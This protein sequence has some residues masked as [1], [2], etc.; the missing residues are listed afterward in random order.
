M[1]VRLGELGRELH[2]DRGQLLAVSAPGRVELDEEEGVLLDGGGEVGLAE[3]QQPL[4]LLVGGRSHGQ[5]QQQ[6]LPQHKSNDTH[7]NPTDRPV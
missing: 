5:Q 2:E 4:S 3:H 6:Q 7:N 1:G